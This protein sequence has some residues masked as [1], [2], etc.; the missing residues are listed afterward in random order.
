MDIDSALKAADGED[1]RNRCHVNSNEDGDRFVGVKADSDKAMVYFP[2]GYQLPETDQEIRTDIKHLIQVLSEFT[3]KEDR[4]LAINKFAAPQTV[5]FPINA[6][7]AVMEFYF[8]LGGKYY[9][10]T[11]PVFRTSSTGNQHWPRTFRN[12][13][14]LVQQSPNGVSSLIYTDFTVRCQILI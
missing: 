12:Q 9:I 10:E 3:S 2:I 14:P 5:D 6:Y 1:I 11:D 4:L 8:S 13:T 7:R